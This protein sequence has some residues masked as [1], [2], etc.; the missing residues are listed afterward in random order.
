MRWLS[1]TRY[2]VPAANGDGSTHTTVP[3]SGRSGMFAVTFVH[4]LASSRLT[5]TNPSSLPA[6]SRPFC[7]GDSA[8]AKTVQYVSAPVL[9]PVI[10]PPD[11]CCFCLSLRVRSS[12]TFSHV[13][14]PSRVR[15]TKLP[16][17]YTVFG[18]WTDAR[19]G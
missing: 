8:R 18:S 11:H 9:S 6:Q 16:P 1:T 13:C 10:G 5:W 7:L 2:A 19:T 12:E 15:K 17:W 14:P 4:V 3:Q